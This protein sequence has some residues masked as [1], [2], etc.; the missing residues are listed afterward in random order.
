MYSTQ[1]EE[2]HAVSE[3]RIRTFLKKTDTW[4]HLQKMYVLIN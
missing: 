2:K 4:L 3:R 1:N